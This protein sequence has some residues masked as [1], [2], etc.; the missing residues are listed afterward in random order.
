MDLFFDFYFYVWFFYLSI[1]FFLTGDIVF[2]LF[3]DD[4]IAHNEHLWVFLLFFTQ[5]K[6]IL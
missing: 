2:N 1:K 4:E 6:H 3:L 5:L